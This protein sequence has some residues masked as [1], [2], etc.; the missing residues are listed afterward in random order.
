MGFEKNK[1][2]FIM[3]ATREYWRVFYVQAVQETL[4]LQQTAAKG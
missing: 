2:T 4:N 3:A 1:R